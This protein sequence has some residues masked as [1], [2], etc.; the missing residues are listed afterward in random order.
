MLFPGTFGSFSTITGF[1]WGPT[2]SARQLGA[3][4]S[5]KATA[6]SSSRDIRTKQATDVCRVLPGQ[7]E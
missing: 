3:D 4:K 6:A 7:R 2:S 1:T 5:A